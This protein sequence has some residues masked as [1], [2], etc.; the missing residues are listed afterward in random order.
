MAVTLGFTGMDSSTQ[1]A[2]AVA[3]RLAIDSNQADVRLQ[4]NADAEVVI[5]DMDSLYGPMSWM[6]LHNAGRSVVGL[7]SAPRTQADFRL[8]R[9]YDGSDLR[10]LLEQITAAAKR[11]G[12]G[13]RT[14]EATPAP[15]PLDIAPAEHA[16]ATLQAPVLAQ[17]A[18]PAQPE[19]EPE[20]VAPPRAS[21]PPAS[22]P[23]PVVVPRVL[24]RARALH[25]WLQPGVL[26]K[27]VRMSQLGAPTL[28]VDV[29]N[30]IYHGPPLLKPVESWLREPVEEDRF[31]TLDIASWK[32][33]VESVGDAQPLS[34][35][36]WFSA[37]KA[38][39]GRLAEGFNPDGEYRLVKWPQTER[40]FPRHFRLATAMMKGP[41]SLR[42]IAD[43]AGASLEEAIDYVNANL[44][45]GFAEQVM[46][47][48]PA[49]ETV[50]RGGL[51]GVR[52]PR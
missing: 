44:A 50:T 27:P 36:L 49:D 33:E 16:K 37:L 39:Q 26:D 51:F 22:V 43:A 12:K 7:T 52:K 17:V 1:D 31:H 13:G 45:T 18:E 4:P 10:V 32:R 35:L 23:A 29:A 48:P 41:A 46:R 14:R 11:A 24:Q 5:V 30:G 3:L 9:P 38:G 20:P 34:R 25:E 6:Q 28:Y 40:E 19:P 8:P 2:L 47:M 15:T 42:S 21:P